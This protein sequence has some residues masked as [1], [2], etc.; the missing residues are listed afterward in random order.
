MG[1]SEVGEVEFPAVEL[2]K[3]VTWQLSPWLMPS[4]VL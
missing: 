2:E 1:G 4:R 3:E